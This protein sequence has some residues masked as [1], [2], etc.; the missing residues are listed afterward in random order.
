MPPHRCTP[1]DYPRLPAID[2][3]RIV[4]VK[5]ITTHFVDFMKSDN[6]GLLSNHIMNLADR[7]ESG[8]RD[9]DCIVIAE[10]ISNALDFAKTGIKVCTKI[11]YRAQSEIHIDKFLAI[12]RFQIARHLAI[13]IPI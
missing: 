6:I 9:N 4:T 11:V 2:I 5:D 7:L 8:T 12:W 1:A 10:L 13:S 3:G